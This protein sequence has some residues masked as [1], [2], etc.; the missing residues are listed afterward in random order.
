MAPHWTR[1]TSPRGDPHLSKFARSPRRL[2]VLEP[3]AEP[4]RNDSAGRPLPPRDREDQPLRLA[5]RPPQG[6]DSLDRRAYPRG[7]ARRLHARREQLGGQLRRGEVFRA[8]GGRV[9]RRSR[10]ADRAGTSGPHLFHGD[11]TVRALRVR[12]KVAEG[13]HGGTVRADPAAATFPLG[14]R[15]S[16]LRG[17]P[18][19]H[20]RAEIPQS[21]PRRANAAIKK[22]L[23]ICWFLPETA[24]MVRK[25]SSVRVRQ[26]A[27]EEKAATGHLWP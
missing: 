11:W 26:R 8:G 12:G 21:P 24:S 10:R 6:A 4:A 2:V 20:A 3:L 27:F 16:P 13:S 17:T 23:E 19:E 15:A 25:G 22:V 7:C 1:S 14:R 9:E 18:K 5:D